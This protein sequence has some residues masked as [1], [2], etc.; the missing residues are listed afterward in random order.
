MDI[1]QNTMVGRPFAIDEK[2]YCIWDPDLDELNLEFICGIDSEYWAF[3]ADTYLAAGTTDDRK[4]Q[5]ALAMRASY[6]QGLETFFA[7]LFATLQAPDCVVG[8]MHKY[9][10]GDLRKL[11]KKAQSRTAIRTRLVSKPRSWEDIA[12]AIFSFAN[13]DNKHEEKRAIVNSYAKL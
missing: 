4:Q 3:L 8:W 7:L 1:D 2:P 13:F 9:E 6:C 5:A 11:V 12:A 10:L